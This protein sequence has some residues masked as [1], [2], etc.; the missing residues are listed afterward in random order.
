[1]CKKHLSLYDREHKNEIQED[2]II[3]LILLIYILRFIA[4]YFEIR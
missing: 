3:C 2:A 1:M 4:L